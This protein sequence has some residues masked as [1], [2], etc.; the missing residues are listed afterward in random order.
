[1]LL[2]ATGAAHTQE[3]KYPYKED[4][5]EREWY[6]QQSIVHCTQNKSFNTLGNEK[7]VLAFCTCKW[8]FVADIFTEEDAAWWRDISH[9]SRD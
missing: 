8:S 2:L 1:M 4:S 6:L 9:L 3:L 7:E 5:P